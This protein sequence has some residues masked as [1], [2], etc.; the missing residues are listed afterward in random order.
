MKAQIRSYFVL[1]CAG[2]ILYP[3]VEI[4]FRGYTHVSMSLLGGICLVAIRWIDLT[5]P[6]LRLPWKAML[7]ALIITQLE[8]ICGL[9]VNC[10]LGLGV[11]DYSRLPWN[12]AGQICPLF[13]FFWFLLSVL[14][15]SYFLLKKKIGKE[16]F[17]LP[18]KNSLRKQHPV[19]PAK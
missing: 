12:L 15:L 6:K 4:L 18:F 10:H 19:K 3:L 16:S 5:V 9:I 2:A 17:L 8:L 7:C 14:V 13:S 1:F 11:W